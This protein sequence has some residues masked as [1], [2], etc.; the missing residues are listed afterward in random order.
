LRIE[1]HFQTDAPAKSLRQCRLQAFSG[2]WC[3]GQLYIYG[4][5]FGHFVRE[6]KKI[7]VLLKVTEINKDFGFHLTITL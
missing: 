4:T 2:E 5:E 6:W 1:K 3:A 7:K